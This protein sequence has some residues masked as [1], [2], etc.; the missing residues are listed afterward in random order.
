MLKCEFS[1]TATYKRSACEEYNVFKTIAYETILVIIYGK[2]S[3]R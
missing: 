2:E 1:Q 3:Q